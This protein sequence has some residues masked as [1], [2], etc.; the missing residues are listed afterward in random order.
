MFEDHQP[1]QPAE[2][3]G[4]DTARGNQQREVGI[5]HDGFARHRN[6]NYAADDAAEQKLPG[7][8]GQ[9]IEIA[10]PS[11]VFGDD[12]TDRPTDT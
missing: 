8:D 7:G 1:E 5:P 11:P 12:R 4:D 9:Q 2:G 6:G 10:A 3:G